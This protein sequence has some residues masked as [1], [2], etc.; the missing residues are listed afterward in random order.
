MDESDRIAHLRAELTILTAKLAIAERTNG[1][2]AMDLQATAEALLEAKQRA[3]AAESHMRE[4]MEQRNAYHAQLEPLHVRI[5]DL[6]SRAT[7]DAGEVAV[8]SLALREYGRMC[9]RWAWR[10]GE[11]VAERAVKMLALSR[12]LEA[13][14]AGAR[15][16]GG[17]E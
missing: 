5:R 10:D 14:Q 16:D 15:K 1:R 2:L 12:K 13:A 7:L 4:V 9:E 6:E 17:D 8:T 11:D 3:D